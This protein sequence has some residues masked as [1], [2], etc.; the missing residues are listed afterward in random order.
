VHWGVVQRVSG[1]QAA[2]GGADHDMSLDDSMHV[3][4]PSRRC[5]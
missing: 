1:V 3:F 4:W 2:G 5:W